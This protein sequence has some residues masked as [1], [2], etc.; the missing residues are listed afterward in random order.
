[1]NR[2]DISVKV[3]LGMTILL[4]PALYVGMKLYGLNGIVG[5]SA[6]MLIGGRIINQA[7]L[8][9]LTPVY[10]PYVASRESVWEFYSE[11]FQ[12]SRAK[13]FKMLGK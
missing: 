3:H 4:P 13:L 6:V 7:I 10:L 11:I 12:K 1:M 9:R 2:N 5:A 8:N